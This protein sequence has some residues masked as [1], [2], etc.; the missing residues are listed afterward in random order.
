[1]ENCW[2]RRISC[3][4]VVAGNSPNSIPAAAKARVIVLNFMTSSQPALHFCFWAEA[5]TLCGSL[6]LG[7]AAVPIED[8]LA[9]P[10][11]HALVLVHVVV[12]LL[13]ILDPVRL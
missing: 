5:R 3:A 9:V 11:Q 2:A 10:M 13:E 1:M 7:N 12:D 6:D 8:L 4:C